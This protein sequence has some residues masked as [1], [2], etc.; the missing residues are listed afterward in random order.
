MVHSPL[1]L[2]GRNFKRIASAPQRYCNTHIYTLTGTQF[3]VFTLQ[4]PH[5]DHHTPHTKYPLLMLADAHAHRVCEITFNLDFVLSPWFSLS[6]VTP[7][8]PNL[9][10]SIYSICTL[11]V[12]SIL[13]RF[14]PSRSQNEASTGSLS[15][16]PITLQ[17]S[18]IPMM[19]LR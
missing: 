19:Q 11:F 8:S 3:F 6:F 7:L 9:L 15:N 14:Q 4:T 10:C 17:R 2:K 1:I 13:S 16:S 5:T 18:F 12:F